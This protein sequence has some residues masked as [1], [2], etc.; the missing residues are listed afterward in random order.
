[1]GRWYKAYNKTISNPSSGDENEVLS[2]K[3]VKASSSNLQ[4]NNSRLK[5]YLE[6]KTM[7]GLKGHNFYEVGRYFIRSLFMEN[8]SVRASS[9]SFNFFLALFPAIIFLLTLIAYL[10][11]EGLKNQFIEQLSIILPERTYEQ[12]SET[13]IEILQKENSGLLSFGF[14]LTVYFT[15]N[16]FHLLIN[17]FNRRLANLDRVKQNWF[18]VRLKAIF[19]AL[20]LSVIIITFL[21]IVTIA[22]QIQFYMESNNWPL[23]DV[24]SFLVELI[25]YILIAGLFL[26]GLSSIY[27][28][29]PSKQSKWQ[30]ISIGS[31][32]GTGLSILA[33]F[34]FTIYVNNFDSY[35]KV[36][37]S[38]GA[39][40][41]LMVL[42]Y[43]NILSMIIG[44]ELNTSIDKA[45][46][47][48]KLRKIK[49]Q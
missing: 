47:N 24:Y 35:N 5:T 42:L 2:K 43:I 13:I 16:S 40:I 14:L 9:L 4:E 7:K 33:T 38:I 28:F 11:Y 19:I 25:K 26:L 45:D 12:I 37:G 32:V 21:I 10:P 29:A 34:T 20:L 31:L 27:Y 3:N 49:N 6:G 1:M 46:L 17:S 41:A 8:L 39:I 23:A 30:F 18:T 44:F 15:S 22:Y 48:K 36:Y